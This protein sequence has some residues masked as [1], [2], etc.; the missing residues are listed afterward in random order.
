MWNFCKIQIDFTFLVP[1]HPGSLGHKAIKWV[2]V[3]YI[4]TRGLTSKIDKCKEWF[5]HFLHLD[6]LCYTLDWIKLLF[7]RRTL[8]TLTKTFTLGQILAILNASV[9]I[10]ISTLWWR[11]IV[12]LMNILHYCYV[13]V[14]LRLQVWLWRWSAQDSMPLWCSKLQKVDELRVISL[15]SITLWIM[16][17]GSFMC[18]IPCQTDRCICDRYVYIIY[19]AG[20]WEAVANC[21]ILNEGLLFCCLCCFVIWPTTVFYAEWFTCSHL[22]SGV[23]AFCVIPLH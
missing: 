22:I 16:L 5:F 2:C 20:L 9:T 7:L 23:V 21:S 10:Q 13:L 15:F 3:W 14:G 4:T 11:Y 18:Q 19:A 17:Y 1:A 8:V 6:I 12:V